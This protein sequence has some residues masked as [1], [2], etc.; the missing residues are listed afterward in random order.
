M[1]EISGSYQLKNE[2]I[3]QLELNLMNEQ[4][5]EYTQC[6]TD[7]N[8]IEPYAQE[9]CQLVKFFCDR[10][11]NQQLNSNLFYLASILGDESI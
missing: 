11:G 8:I 3:A 9:F 2:E 5:L 6:C 1:I 7:A 10:Q 4:L